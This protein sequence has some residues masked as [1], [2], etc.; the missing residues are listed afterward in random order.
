MTNTETDVKETCLRGLGDVSR[1]VQLTVE[2]HSQVSNNVCRYDGVAADIDMMI[3][4]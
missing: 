3:T 1:H 2:L 4:I